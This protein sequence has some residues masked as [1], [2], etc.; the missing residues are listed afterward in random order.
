LPVGSGCPRAVIF[1]YPLVL[2]SCLLHPRMPLHLGGFGFDFGSASDR[3]SA[4]AP[5]L[6]QRFKAKLTPNARGDDHLRTPGVRPS[7]P[8]SDGGVDGGTAVLS[9]TCC[10]GWQ[11]WEEY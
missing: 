2:S 11:L 1:C 9:I 6:R 8:P 4:L 7:A 3:S 10:Y 5:G